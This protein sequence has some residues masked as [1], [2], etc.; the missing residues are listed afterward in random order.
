MKKAT[1]KTAACRF[2]ALPKFTPGDKA[3]APKLPSW[4]T[5]DDAPAVRPH[6]RKERY[7][8]E[9]PAGDAT[10]YPGDILVENGKAF[11]VYSAEKFLELFD[12]ADDTPA[13]S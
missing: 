6:P 9:T 1:L 5:A 13:A 12:V 2:V 4:A 7:K 10:A 8:V 11:E 3:K